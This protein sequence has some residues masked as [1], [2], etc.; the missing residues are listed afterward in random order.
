MINPLVKSDELGANLH[1]GDH[2]VLSPEGAVLVT[3]PGTK[4]SYRHPPQYLNPS[5]DMLDGH[6]GVEDFGGGGRMGGYTSVLRPTL[7]L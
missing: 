7:S 5:K 2:V 1:V 6:A 3:S 4:S